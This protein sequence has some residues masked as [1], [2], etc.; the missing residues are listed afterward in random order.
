MA[1][2]CCDILDRT[3]TDCVRRLDTAQARLRAFCPEPPYTE[4]TV[5]ELRLYQ[6]EVEESR[7]A[8]ENAKRERK[9]HFETHAL[10]L[11]R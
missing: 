6:R 10:T 8:L 4:A 3:E 7:V 9:A 1:C 11:S 2:T 5:S